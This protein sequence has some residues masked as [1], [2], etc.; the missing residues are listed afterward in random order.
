MLC[1]LCPFAYFR[2]DDPFYAHDSADPSTLCAEAIFAVDLLAAHQNSTS[3]KQQASADQPATHRPH[4]RSK[5]R[6]SSKE[7][8]PGVE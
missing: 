6:T 1:G 8:N 3:L 5:K 2:P 7:R 4:L